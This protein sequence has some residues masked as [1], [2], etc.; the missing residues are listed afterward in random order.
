[1]PEHVLVVGATGVVGFAA[2]KQF[3]G[4]SDCKLTAVSRREPLER[5]GADFLPLDLTDAAACAQAARDLPDVTRV[6]YAALYERPGLVAGWLE[7]EQIETNRRMLENLL[8]PLGETARGL[9]HVTLLQGTKAYGVH[10]APL[11]IPARENR[12]ERRDV[13]N[14]YWDQED[15]LRSKPGGGPWHWTILRPQIVFGLS[16]GSAMN[17]IPAIGTYAALKRERGE[18]LDYPG[19][20]G[21]ILEAVDADLLARVIDWA[22]S[23]PQARDEVF[24]VT[25]GDVFVWHNVWPAIADALGM[26]PG[27]HTPERLAE[28]MPPQAEAWDA[29]R[30][31]HGLRAPGLDAFVGKSF[32]YADFCMAYGADRA[33]SPAL[34]S[35]TK[36]RQAGFHEVMD[37]EV[38][39]RKWFA[40]FQDRRLLPDP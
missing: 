4:R 16:L 15:L 26:T 14:F 36:L 1:M 22:G 29:V 33:V 18:A 8:V 38:M 11:A 20:L 7:A 39:F 17:L 30:E 40:E 25:N 19:G 31:R 34:V 28:T 37:S 2:L 32:H 24:N 9:R 12:S 35:T 13:P 5:F 27:Q 21:P 10:V 23:S 6:V 3:G